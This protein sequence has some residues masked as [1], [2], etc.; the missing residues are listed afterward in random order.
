MNTTPITALLPHRFPFLFV[1][2]IE[3]ADQQRIVGTRRFGADE[4]FFT[5]HFPEYAVVPGV[6]L[7]EAMAQTGGAGVKLLGTLGED[8]LLF[9]ATIEKAK[10]RRQ[11]RPNETVRFEVENLRVSPRMLRQRGTA[12]VDGEVACEAEWMCVVADSSAVR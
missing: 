10:F 6:L 11:V 9:L 3:H 5:G 12:S 4:P 2:S 7:V 1:D 8:R